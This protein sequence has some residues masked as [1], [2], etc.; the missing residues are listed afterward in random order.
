ML[1]SYK[2]ALWSPKPS[3]GTCLHEGSGL[4]DLLQHVQAH[5]VR[6]GAAVGLHA[7]GAQG[8]HDLLPRRVQLQRTSKL[9]H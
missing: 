8:S 3:A 7:G 1:Y 2:Q 9:R 4:R 5:E 6:V